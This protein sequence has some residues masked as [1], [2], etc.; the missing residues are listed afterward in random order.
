[1][2]LVKSNTERFPAF[3]S[4]LSDFFNAENLSINDL[5]E[6]SRIPAVNVSETEKSYE[7]ELAAPGM[8]KGDFK[9]R[10]DDGIISISSEQKD[11]KEEK[12]KHYTRREFSYRS[13]ERS[14]TLPDNAKEDSVKAVYEEGVLRISI[15]KK[16]IVSN[17][18]KE[19]KVS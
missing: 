9:I 17:K 2:T 13:F 6:K 16:E 5:F 11:E 14:F 3:R 4:L 1:M 10:V 7:L 19:I 15:D 8:K 12:N 18:T